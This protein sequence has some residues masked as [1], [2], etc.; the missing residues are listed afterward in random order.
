MEASGQGYECQL[1]G[2]VLM[3]EEEFK[4][5]NKALHNK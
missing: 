3:T 1:C 4:E 5:H 2:A